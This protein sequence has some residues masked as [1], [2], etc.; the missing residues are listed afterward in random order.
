MR[1]P[2]NGVGAE[3]GLAPHDLSQGL[4]VVALGALHLD[5]EVG[6]TY[7]IQ[8]FL[9]QPGFDSVKIFQE[10]HARSLCKLLEVVQDERFGL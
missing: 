5:T 1:N 7:Q 8:V 2:D 9:I 10:R 3:G 4:L 6:P